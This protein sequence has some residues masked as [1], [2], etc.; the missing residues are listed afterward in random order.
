MIPQLEVVVDETH[1]NPKYANQVGKIISVEGDVCT[2][3]LKN[4]DFKTNAA[5]ILPVRPEKNEKVIVLKGKS[6]GQQGTII[7][8]STEDK[9]A[10]VELED[11]N[12]SVLKLHCLGK[13]SNDNNNDW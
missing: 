2:L 7:N 8:K 13:F 6:K 4:G 9:E 3:R 12:I 11:N 10:V 5:Y 1:P